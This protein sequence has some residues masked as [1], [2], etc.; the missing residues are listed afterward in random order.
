MRHLRALTT[1]LC[2]AG[3][4]TTACSSGDKSGAGETSGAM[5]ADS[6][7]VPAPAIQT[8]AVA[9]TDS[10][11]DAQIISTVAVINGSEILAA[12]AAQ[13]KAMS[14]DVKAFAKQ[15]ITDHTMMQGMVD[16][17][18]KASN[19]TPQSPPMADTLQNAMK[20]QLDSI[21]M[22]KGKAFDQ[23]YVAAQVAAHQ[24]ALDLLNR[25]ATSAQ[26]AGLKTVLQQGQTKV[27][28]HLD[29]ARTLQQKVSAGS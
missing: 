7:A 25:F 8:A 12:K 14:S 29:M 4:L 15:M 28:S 21:S 18:A 16:S 10:V 3:L 23:A 2:C 19:L 11:S 24:K 27:Q 5:A 1:T 17:V 22:L 26:N 6:M 9:P 20:M 13:K